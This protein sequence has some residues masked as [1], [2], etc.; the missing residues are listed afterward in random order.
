MPL[1]RAHPP[2]HALHVVRL[3]QHSV[4]LRRL[5]LPLEMRRAEHRGRCCRCVCRV[6]LLLL[7]PPRQASLALLPLL[8]RVRLVGCVLLPP[9]ARP[10]PVMCVGG[11][12]RV[13]EFGA[14]HARLAKQQHSSTPTT[15]NTAQHGAAQR[16]A[17]GPRPTSGAPGRC[18]R[19][20]TA[21]ARQAPGCQ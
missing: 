7:L 16:S 17:A 1:N 14:M 21:A 5:R 19:W 2:Q 10:L 3:H 15:P 11:H 13:H 4:P 20:W 12:T 9:P 6:L 8:L 18:L